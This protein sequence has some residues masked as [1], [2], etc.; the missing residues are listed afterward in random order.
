MIGIVPTVGSP[1]QY[2]I[3]GLVVGASGT[4]STTFSADGGTFSNVNGSGSMPTAIW[5][6]PTVCYGTPLSCTNSGAS[7][8]T[9]T[10]SA[11]GSAFGTT[12]VTVSFNVIQ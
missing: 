11:G 7:K 1:R 8:I 6:P 4:P 10:T 5:T 9:M 2:M 12:T 3:K